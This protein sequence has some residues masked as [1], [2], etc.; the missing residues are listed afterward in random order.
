MSKAGTSGSMNEN[1]PPERKTKK[2]PW[3]EVSDTSLRAKVT[4]MYNSDKVLNEEIL[5]EL[6]DELIKRKDASA[7]NK[8]EFKKWQYYI[9]KLNVIILKTRLK[10]TN[11]SDNEYDEDSSI[12][13][14]CDESDESRKSSDNEEY[15][16]KK[17]VRT[18]NNEN[19]NNFA[20][21]TISDYVKTIRPFKG[22][23]GEWRAFKNEVQ[24]GI[25]SNDYVPS[26]MKRTL[27]TS[28]LENEPLTVWNQ[29][30]A[31]GLKV[32]K[33][34]K[35]LSKHYENDRNIRFYITDRIAQMKP[36]KSDNDK[37]GLKDILEQVKGF[38]SAVKYLGPVHQ[39]RAEGFVGNIADKFWEKQS[40]RIWKKCDTLK[41]LEKHIETLYQDSIAIEQKRSR[42]RKETKVE[43]TNNNCLTISNVNIN[44]CVFCKGS[45][46]VSTECRT[47][48]N[49]S[50]KKKIIKEKRLCSKCLESGHLSSG[51]NRSFTCNQCRGDHATSMHG[52]IFFSQGSMEHQPGTS[53]QV[54][55]HIRVES[56]SSESTM[57]F[58]FDGSIDGKRCRTLL[59]TGASISLVSSKL[60][61]S[62]DCRMVEPIMLRG[63]RD[64][65]IE[66]INRLAKIKVHHKNGAT[67]I[68]AYVYNNMDND[69]VIVGLKHF[70]SFLLEGHRILRTV[71]GDY[72]FERN[73][74][75]ERTLNEPKDDNDLKVEDEHD[76]LYKVKKLTSGRYRINF[77]LICNIQPPCN[78]VSAAKILFRLRDRLSKNY[79]LMEY[80]AQLME[81]EQTGFFMHKFVSNSRMIENEFGLTLDEKLFSLPWKLNSSI[82]PRMNQ[83]DLI[84]HVSIWINGIHQEKDSKLKQNIAPI[85]TRNSF[86]TI[87]VIYQ[88][89]ETGGFDYTYSNNDKNHH[90]CAIINNASSQPIQHLLNEGYK[91][92]L[93]NRVKWKFSTSN[94]ECMIRLIEECLFIFDKKYY[95]A[96][97]AQRSVNVE[98]FINRISLLKFKTR[99]KS[100]QTI[101]QF[102]RG[103]MMNYS[104][105]A[106]IVIT[107][108]SLSS[109]RLV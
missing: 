103:R 48:I 72:D 13:D 16:P 61:T 100:Q 94:A 36:V 73:K 56:I 102:P 91:K 88:Q 18:K 11:L 25:L 44:N 92:G 64:G 79:M 35:L 106:S 27:I 29:G 46:H 58:L 77:P 69:R 70:G 65:M 5:T 39:A 82:L 104:K 12:Y 42:G 80:K 78:F 108:D 50:E 105:I 75:I 97:K 1:E 59:D 63:Y 45:N 38:R 20:R 76:W 4:R 67:Q 47:M 15:E 23:F 19:N 31:D 86:D 99:W 14:E 107:I 101:S 89:S 68:E 10:N 49:F 74:L 52:V 83:M 6:S 40:D 8:T 62:K 93:I 71:F 43:R 57:N 90:K 87:I 26:Y 109:L 7:S 95:S 32:E 84:N 98:Y 2:G 9:E 53:T 3:N 96:L 17:K 33:C 55:Q 21:I 28:L 60:V 81:L 24:D 34:W 37:Q 30:R 41:Q 51:C 22:D 85:R 66:K 54:V